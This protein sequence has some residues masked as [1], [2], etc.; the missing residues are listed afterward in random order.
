M[1][2]VLS[3]LE[4]KQAAML[5][6]RTVHLQLINLPAPL[7]HEHAMEVCIGHIVVFFGQPFVKTD[8]AKDLVR[9][10]QHKQNSS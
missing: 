9:L 1:V 3:N 5:F 2:V 4:C 8:F 6:V 7:F 10:T